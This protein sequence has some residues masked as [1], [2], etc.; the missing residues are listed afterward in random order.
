LA[1]DEFVKKV[2]EDNK[3]E[4]EEI[5]ELQRIL[6]LLGKREPALYAASVTSNA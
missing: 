3:D 4:L 5:R 2:L 6:G 1:L